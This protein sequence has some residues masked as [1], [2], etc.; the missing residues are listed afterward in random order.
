[1]F[2]GKQSF[3]WLFQMTVRAIGA[4]IE[5]LERRG[6]GGEAIE[7]NNICDRYFEDKPIDCY[8]TGD[9]EHG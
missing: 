8:D 6:D 3:T 2:V 9:I 4:E 7:Q 5:K 1:M